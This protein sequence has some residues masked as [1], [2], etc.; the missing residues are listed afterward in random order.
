VVAQARTGRR[1]T[2]RHLSCVVHFPGSGPE[3]AVP[4]TSSLAPR[5]M[6][7]FGHRSSAGTAAFRPPND[8]ST[9]DHRPAGPSAE[10]T[11]GDMYTLDCLLRRGIPQATVPCF[12]C[13]RV[14]LVYLVEVG[15]RPTA[16]RSV[17]RSLTLKC[18][19]GSMSFVN[20]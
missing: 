2:L 7:S 17:E 6:Q 12:A 8:D 15:S 3:S 19:V 1:I 11:V 13:S 14:G 20:H 5:Q 10:K 4:L 16:E 9:R 18:R